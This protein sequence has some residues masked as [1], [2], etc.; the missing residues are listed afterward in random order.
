MLFGLSPKL[1]IGA[2][3]NV[4]IEAFFRPLAPKSATVPSTSAPI[5]T[6]Q[7]DNEPSLRVISVSGQNV[8]ENPSGS[9]NSPDVVFTEP[10]EISVIV[11]G[12]NVPAQTPIKLRVTTPESTINLPGAEQ[13]PVLLGAD[14]FANFSL[15]VPAGLGTIQAFAEFNIGN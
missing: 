14:G 11:Q 5:S 9:I 12:I 4:R 1:R 13:T 3:E 6:F 10:G 7:F 8:S 15:T 2:L